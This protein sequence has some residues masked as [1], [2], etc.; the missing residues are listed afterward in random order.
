MSLSTIILIAIHL[1]AEGALRFIPNLPDWAKTILE[2]LAGV[3]MNAQHLPDDERK[4]IVANARA[5]AM[6]SVHLHCSGVSCPP[7]LKGE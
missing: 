1:G 6:K 5:E 7:E 3:K 4:E 2:L